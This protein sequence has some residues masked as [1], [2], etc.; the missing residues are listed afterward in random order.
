MGDFPVVVED[1]RDFSCLG[2]TLKSGATGEAGKDES[3]HRVAKY[4]LGLAQGC[5]LAEPGC[6]SAQALLCLYSYCQARKTCGLTWSLCFWKYCLSHYS[7]V[8][9]STKKTIGKATSQS[10]PFCSYKTFRTFCSL[11]HPSSK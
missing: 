2:K 7:K 4:E 3:P 9:S 11:S 1:S 5:S 6:S 8:S 10:H